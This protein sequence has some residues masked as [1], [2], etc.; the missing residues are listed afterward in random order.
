MAF[1]IKWSYQASNDRI[2]ILEFWF[3]R[4]G[5][6]T[7]SK[8]LNAKF[9]R[10]INHLAKFTFSGRILDEKGTRYFVVDNY[11]IIY[12]SEDN[13]INILGIFDGRRNPEDLTI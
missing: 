1:K 13:V 10:C 8:K 6:K 2:E 7:Y 4:I 9:N 3:I 5:T 12:T 11:F